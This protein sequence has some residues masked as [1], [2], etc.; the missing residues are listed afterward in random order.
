MIESN[1]ALASVRYTGVIREDDGQAEGFDEVWHVS[2][3][4]SDSNATWKLAGIQPL[5][6]V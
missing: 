6:C 1:K 2:K 5:A 4:L 3:N